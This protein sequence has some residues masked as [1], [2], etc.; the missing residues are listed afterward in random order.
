MAPL[1][2]NPRMNDFVFAAL[3]GYACN[4]WCEFCQLDWPFKDC[5]CAKYTGIRIQLACCNVFLADLLF[6]Y[7]ASWRPE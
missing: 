1:V 4:P 5:G 7:S 6:S 3:G 2:K